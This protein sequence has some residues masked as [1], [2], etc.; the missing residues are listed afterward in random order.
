MR[1]EVSGMPGSAGMLSMVVW[2]STA[3][4]PAVHRTAIE[5]QQAGIYVLA[6]SGK[7]CWPVKSA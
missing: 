6:V 2:V 7:E 1:S 3:M 5:R 4:T